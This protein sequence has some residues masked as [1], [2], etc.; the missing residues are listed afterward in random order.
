MSNEL[1][2][3][4]V[5]CAL[6]I[7]ENQFVEYLRMHGRSKSRPIMDALGLGGPCDPDSGH[8][9]WAFGFICTRLLDQKRIV[10]HQEK[11]G[12]RKEFE[13]V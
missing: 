9:G 1:L 5:E 10:M 11:K 8:H 13:A 7:I 6:R 4:N 3:E 12:G 2:K